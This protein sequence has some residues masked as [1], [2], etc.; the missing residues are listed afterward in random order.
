MLYIR[1]RLRPEKVVVDESS[2]SSIK[3]NTLSNENTSLL[4]KY[5]SNGMKKMTISIPPNSL[6]SFSKMFP[7]FVFT[8]KYDYPR[9]HESTLS[10]HYINTKSLKDINNMISN[11]SRKV[12]E[13]IMPYATIFFKYWYTK[14]AL[15]LDNIYVSLQKI[16]YV[17]K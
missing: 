15:P 10:I 9:L 17:L 16:S 6:G 13:K 2:S 4:K 12:A 14:K 3:E 7:N 8:E 11:T 1:N 5:I